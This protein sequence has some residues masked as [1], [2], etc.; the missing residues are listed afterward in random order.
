M[1]QPGVPFTV[2]RFAVRCVAWRRVQVRSGRVGVLRVGQSAG[3]AMKGREETGMIRS[4]RSSWVSKAGKP[5]LS[6][7]EAGV[8][9]TVRPL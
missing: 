9:F 1:V 8:I 3:H 5:C 4:V 7:D 6:R 2:F